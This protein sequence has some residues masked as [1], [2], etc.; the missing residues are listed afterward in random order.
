MSQASRSG[1][2]LQPAYS[3]TTPRET[4]K[5]R[6][7]YS[8]EVCACRYKTKK[9]CKNHV[10]DRHKRLSC[11]L[12]SHQENTKSRIHNHLVH[13]HQLT[14]KCHTCKET[15]SDEFFLA[16][17]LITKHWDDPEKCPT[18]SYQITRRNNMVQHVASH[19]AYY[20]QYVHVSR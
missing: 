4:I 8:C 17:H 18:C 9:A 3:V 11:N 13:F 12:C 5:S 14:S 7:V 15:F 1:N 20:M 6:G 2:S 16:R 10:N 19:H